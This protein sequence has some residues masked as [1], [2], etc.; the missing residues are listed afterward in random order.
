M[1]AARP[2][3][4]D[5]LLSLSPEVIQSEVAHFFSSQIVLFGGDCALVNPD[6]SDFC[7]AECIA[8]GIIDRLNSL[9]A[10]SR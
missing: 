3:V 4:M 9:P 2:G 10:L 7:L 5:S 6:V 1:S 8:L